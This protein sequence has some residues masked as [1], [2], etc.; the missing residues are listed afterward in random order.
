[1]SA[2]NQTCNPQGLAA[3]QHSA[4]AVDHQLE[5]LCV[6]IA[7]GPVGPAKPF[8]FSVF[9]TDSLLTDDCI[10]IAHPFL[11]SSSIGISFLV[12]SHM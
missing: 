3:P 10:S 4:P 2:E 8:L 11:L 5:P 6:S 12:L 9:C 7:R 1:M